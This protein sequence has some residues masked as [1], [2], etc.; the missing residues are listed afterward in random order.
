M[1]KNLKKKN[2]KRDA[3][4][5]WLKKVKPG[6]TLNKSQIGEWRFKLKKLDT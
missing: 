4:T 5:R 3:S 6:N 1:R 2:E